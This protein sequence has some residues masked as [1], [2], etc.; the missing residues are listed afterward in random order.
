MKRSAIRGDGFPGLR[1]A[2]S[3]LRFV[4]RR[5]ARQ[6]YPR[7]T[8]VQ[9]T[10]DGTSVGT[11]VSLGS[12]APPRTVHFMDEMSERTGTY[13]Q[14]VRGGASGAKRIKNSQLPI[15][16]SPKIMPNQSPL[17]PRQELN[18]HAPS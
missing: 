7:L 2:S 3:G 9:Y 17:A 14:R 18:Y 6:N 12:D 1:C 4:E 11:E 8:A 5:A 15:S 16:N 13:L 10:F